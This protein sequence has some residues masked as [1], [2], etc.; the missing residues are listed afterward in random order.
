MKKKAIAI[1]GVGLLCMLGTELTFGQGYAHKYGVEI[2]GGIRE[3]G[4]DRG[5]RYFLAERPDYQAVG[6][7]F[8]YYVNPSFDATVYGSVGD[9]GHRDDSYPKKLGFTARVT[10]LMLG[11][12]YKISNGYIMPEDSRIRP[13]IQAGWGGMQSVSRIIHNVP[14]YGENRSWVAAHWSAGVGVRVQLTDILDLSLQ[15]LYNYTFDDNYDGLPFSMGRLRLNAMHDAYLYHSVGFVVN[16]GE[17]D[18]AYRF[19]KDDEEVPKEVVARVNLAARSIQFETASAVIKP[20][21]YAEL[22]TIVEILLDYPTI[23]ALI[24]GH[25]DDVGDDES[26]MTLSQNRAAAVKKY[27]EGKGVDAMRLT[28]K[29]YG[30]TQ[31]IKS[32]KSEEGRQANRR[33]EVKLYYRK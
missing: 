28:A 15:S 7:S 21:S 12:R 8:S 3:Y 18:G 29:G 23:D 1:L 22:D 33:V 25:T 26:N 31:P 9:L 11:L 5:T 32:N 14:G 24:E 6:L 20:E 16:F 17:N 30:E 2:N 10:D 19:G 13:Y 4:G 27:I